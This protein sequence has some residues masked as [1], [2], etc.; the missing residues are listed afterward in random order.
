MKNAPVMIS[1]F[2]SITSFICYFSIISFGMVISLLYDSIN[3]FG[4]GMIF[5]GIALFVGYRSPNNKELELWES[6]NRFYSKS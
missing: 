1:R 3:N 4:F 2:S 6:Q 5:T